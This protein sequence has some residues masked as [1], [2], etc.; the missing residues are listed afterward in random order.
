MK[1]FWAF[2]TQM[3]KQAIRALAV[4]LAMFA[5][6]V[7]ILILGKESFG[8]PESD[9][10][11]VFNHVNESGYGLPL[12]ILI[13][14]FAAFIGLPQWALI[15]G[16][17]L[18]FGPMNGAIYSWIATMV[19]AS[20]DFWLG[21]WMGAERLRRY[22]GHIVNRIIN[23]VRENGFVTSFAVRFVPTGPFILVNM[24][25]GVA[26]MKFL[27]FALGTGLGII[28]KIAVVSLVA[29]GVISRSEGKSVTVAFVALALIIV[30]VMFLAR[31]RL[32]ESNA[33]RQNNR[34]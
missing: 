19:S 15:A 20:V 25:A 17:V 2:V 1:A 14:V 31:R 5:M 33:F 24:A 26:R 12:T 7:L 27:S 10:Y 18:A 22:G 3:D 34:D 11:K 32:Q 4:L 23:V 16:V 8:L 30:V 6:V 9:F 29:Q 21:R 28:P 13:F